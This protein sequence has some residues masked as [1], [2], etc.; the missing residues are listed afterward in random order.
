MQ[1]G[2]RGGKG[3]KKHSTG[4]KSASSFNRRPEKNVSGF[5][6]VNPPST[7]I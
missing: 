6:N 5:Y 1:I 7:S 2:R 3:G 4:S